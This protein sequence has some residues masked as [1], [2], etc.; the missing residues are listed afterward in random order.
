VPLLAWAAIDGAPFTLE[1]WPRLAR[2]FVLASAVLSIGWRFDPEPLTPRP[3]QA[4]IRAALKVVP[5][6][7][8]V[9]VENWF[10]AHLAG[11]EAV[12]FCVLWEW[13]RGRYE[14]YR[15]PESSS[16]R[17]QVFDVADTSK[18]HPALAARLAALRSAGAEV[19]Y[20]HDGVTVLRVDEG[21]LA[22]APVVL[23]PPPSAEFTP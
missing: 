15:W 14:Y 11:R 16:A 8:P 22:R 12:D 23:A 17:W 20:D 9:C 19:M 13:D 7:E 4:A 2:L 6:G 5:D 3:N 21:V 18:E 10:G 1:K